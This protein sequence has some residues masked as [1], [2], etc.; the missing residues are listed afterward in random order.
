MVTKVHKLNCNLFSTQKRHFSSHQNFFII[1]NWSILRLWEDF[2]TVEASV[3]LRLQFYSLARIYQFEF[4]LMWEYKCYTKDCTP[5]HRRAM[6]QNVTSDCLVC[7]VTTWNGDLNND[8]ACTPCRSNSDTNGEAKTSA[9][10]CG[11][12]KNICLIRK[13]VCN[14]EFHFIVCNCG[15]RSQTLVNDKEEIFCTS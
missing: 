3:K 2:P 1:S 10:D 12:R 15:I 11:E 5:G 4:F 6:D 7:P 14:S 13:S 8:E 9:S